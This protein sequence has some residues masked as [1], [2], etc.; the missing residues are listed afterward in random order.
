MHEIRRVAYTI[1]LCISQKIWKG[2][3][4]WVLSV[5]QGIKVDICWWKKSQTTTWD[6]LESLKKNGI[7]YQPQ[8]VSRISS[9]NSIKWWFSQSH[10]CFFMKNP[11]QAL[12]FGEQFG[13]IS[14]F[15]ERAIWIVPESS[16]SQGTMGTHVSFIFRGYNPYIWGVE[17]PSFFMVWGSKGSKVKY[18]PN[19]CLI[20]NVHPRWH[21]HG[22]SHPVLGCSRK[23]GSM[24]R[25]NG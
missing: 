15:G 20:P 13:A 18:I 11:S 16:K 22:L 2:D 10:S 9:I 3:E 14:Q 1:H 6:V 7:N 19:E 5:S 8:L 4:R 25:I 24:L 12:I 21:G 23:L 17:K